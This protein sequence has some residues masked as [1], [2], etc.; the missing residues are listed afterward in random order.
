MTEETSPEIRERLLFML[1]GMENT[2]I[3]AVS[4]DKRFYGPYVFR[5]K[6][7]IVSHGKL[8]CCL[9]WAEGLEKGRTVQ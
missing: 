2:H 1:Q 8:G 6:A 4:C 3:E 5:R 9:C 7:L